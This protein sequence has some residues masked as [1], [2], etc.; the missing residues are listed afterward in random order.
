WEGTNR[1]AHKETQR[2]MIEN[3]ITGKIIGAAIEVHKQLGPGLLESVYQNCL[4][5]ELLQMDMLVEKEKPLP[6]VYK[7]VKLD[8]GFR[9]DLFVEKKVIVE[10]KSVESLND[11]H[12]AQVLTYMKLTETRIGLLINFNVTKLTHGIKRIIN[13]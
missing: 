9:L 12:M 11:I 1:R 7:D 8:C 4:F 6:V 13:G 5:F 2:W 3:S 10:I